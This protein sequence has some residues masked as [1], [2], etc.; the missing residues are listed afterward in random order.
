MQIH[1]RIH[2]KAVPP[3][4]YNL[5]NQLS[6]DTISTKKQNIIP[7]YSKTTYFE[8]NINFDSIFYVICHYVSLSFTSKMER[9]PDHGSLLTSFLIELV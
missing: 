5:L 2:P 1:T 6:L 9:H 7:T 8:E 3:N 4:T